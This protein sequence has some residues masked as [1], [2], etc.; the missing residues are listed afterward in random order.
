MSTPGKGVVL[1]G[2][3]RGVRK[4]GKSAVFNANG[5]CASCCE[6]P[7]EYC[8]GRTPKT[9]EVVFSGLTWCCMNRF[10]GTGDKYDDDLGNLVD[11]LLTQKPDYPCQWESLVLLGYKSYY[12]NL[13]QDVLF[14]TTQ[15]SCTIHL[16]KLSDTSWILDIYEQG[17]F[18]RIFRHTLTGQASSCGGNLTFTNEITECRPGEG[19]PAAFGGS[20]TVSV[21]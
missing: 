10:D 15:V 4:S 12:G 16:E 2:G 7:C 3:K 9:F 18:G 13:C 17:W 19:S 1:A 11:V 21:P 20:A 6:V 5:A 14:D 8:D